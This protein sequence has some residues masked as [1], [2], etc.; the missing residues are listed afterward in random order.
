MLHSLVKSFRQGLDPGFRRAAVKAA[1]LS[2]GL[3]L[4]L[5]GLAA[6]A[7]PCLSVL[8]V[9]WLD[10]LVGLVGGLGALLLA[11]LLFPAVAGIAVGLFLEDVAD[12]VEAHHYPDLPPASGGAASVLAAIRLSGLALA[13]NLL[14]LPV[15]LLPGP[16]VFVFFAINGYLLGREY[17]E[18]AALRRMSTAAARGLRRKNAWRVFAA[19]CLIT[20]LLSI[21]VVGWSMPIIAAAFMVHEVAAVARA[22]RQ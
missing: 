14:L 6:W 19:G 18:L 5:A 22:D 13:L 2:A 11:I 3:F 15:Y 8:G 10:W 21:P 1:V 16:N 7:L 9:G 20:V 12:A 17:F 4:A